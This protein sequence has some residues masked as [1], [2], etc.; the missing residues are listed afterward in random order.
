MKDK[1]ANYLY[2]NFKPE[3]PFYDL[4][5][6]YRYEAH[7]RKCNEIAEDLLRILEGKEPKKKKLSGPS[8][9]GPR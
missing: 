1:L 9:T 5:P 8:N 3:L 7:E 6:M 2:D 4:N